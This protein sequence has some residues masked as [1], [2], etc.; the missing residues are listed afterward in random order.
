MSNTMKVRFLGVRGSIATPSP[1]TSGVGGN[2]SCVEVRVGE[3][4][5]ILDAGTGIRAL[6]EQLLRERV[7]NATSL[8]SHLHWDHI[9][10]LP[11]FIPA[12]LPSA[13]LDVI[14][15]PSTSTPH[16][17]IKESLEM[18]MQPPHFP[19]R[20]SDM[21]ACVTFRALDSGQ[22]IDL[23]GGLVKV[24]ARRLNHPGGVMGYRIEA[25][26]KSVVYAT[27]TEHYACS[28]P[29]LV[30]LRQRARARSHPITASAS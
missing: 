14:G 24:K 8:F 2:T 11:F 10:G 22:R 27:D 6:G 5:L 20:L 16:L 30:A 15:V 4:V 26:G 18:Q 19:V 23:Y 25:F 29:Y 21:S 7:S 3:H 13:C 12:W 17:G 28:D 1:E 9:R